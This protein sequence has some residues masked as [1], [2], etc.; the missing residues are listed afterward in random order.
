MPALTIL[1]FRQK[2]SA[3]ARLLCGKQPMADGQGIE[4]ILFISTLRR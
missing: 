2:R 1:Q 3:P 4:F